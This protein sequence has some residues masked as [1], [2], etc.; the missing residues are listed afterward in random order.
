MG[1]NAAIMFHVK[2]YNGHKPVVNAE[3][4]IFKGRSTMLKTYR[5]LCSIHITHCPVCGKKLESTYKMVD[6]VVIGD[7]VKWGKVK[8]CIHHSTDMSMGSRVVSKNI[9]QGE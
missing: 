2:H 6:G 5:Q 9:S 1:A 7:S 3:W 4:Q 8:I